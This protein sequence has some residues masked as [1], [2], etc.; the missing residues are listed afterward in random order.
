MPMTGKPYHQ[1]KGMDGSSE[2]KPTIS[3]G[4]ALEDAPEF[5][6]ERV[7]FFL[8]R[9]FGD[10]WKCIQWPGR[11]RVGERARGPKIESRK[12]GLLRHLLTKT[13]RWDSLARSR[14]GGFIAILRSE[15]QN[16]GSMQKV[17]TSRPRQFAISWWTRRTPEFFSGQE[18]G[19]LSGAQM[20]SKIGSQGTRIPVNSVEISQKWHQKR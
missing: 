9:K 11:A 12:H 3:V 14:R 2:Q 20:P 5:E 1:K 15:D 7:A 8:C 4:L 19:L 6:L 13:P 18:K 17:G 10:V 16:R